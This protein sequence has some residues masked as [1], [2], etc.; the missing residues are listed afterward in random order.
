MATN[1]TEYPN[2]RQR[3]QELGCNHPSGFSLLPINFETA[4]SI[5]EFRQVAEAAT[6]KTLLR[7]AN[8]PYADIVPS[9]QRPA[10]VQNNSLDWAAPTLFVS[11]NLLSQNPEYVELAFDLILN[12]LE[13]FFRG[14]DSGK[15][16]KLNIVVERTEKETCKKVYY[17]GPKE[18]LKEIPEIIKATKDE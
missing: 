18:G 15:E 9:E 1:I 3:L 4:D 5:E 6:V 16:V 7:S 13:D 8:L 12:Y 14:I 2:V 11:A 17:E 10:Y